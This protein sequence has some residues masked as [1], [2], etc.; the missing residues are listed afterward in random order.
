MKKTEFGLEYLI[1]NQHTIEASQRRHLWRTVSTRNPEV[2][3]F[4]KNSPLMS[5]ELNASSMFFNVSTA[6]GWIIPKQGSRYASD[7]D[8]SNMVFNINA[9]STIVKTSVLE[10]RGVLGSDTIEGNFIFNVVA[11]ST[12]VQGSVP[13]EDTYVP[14]TASDI[15]TTNFDFQITSKNVVVR[16]SASETANTGRAAGNIQW[17][18]EPLIITTSQG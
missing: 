11:K 4:E 17:G 15:T 18:I 6:A 9:R 2:V 3:L 5:H 8:G 1:Q 16:A 13:V 12:V 7:I 14:R 10:S